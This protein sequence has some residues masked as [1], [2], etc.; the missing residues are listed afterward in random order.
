MSLYRDMGAILAGGAPWEFESLCIVCGAEHTT[1]TFSPKKRDYKGPR[2]RFGTCGGCIEEEQEEYDERQREF[3][4][5]SKPK[6]AEIPD[7]ET[8][9]LKHLDDSLQEDAF[10]AFDDRKDTHG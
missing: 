8:A 3:E 10:D 4:E 9:K 6:E 2:F 7:L 5:S 1:M